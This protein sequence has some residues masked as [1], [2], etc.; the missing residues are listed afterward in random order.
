MAHLVKALVYGVVLIVGC[1][2]ISL[3]ANLIMDLVGFSVYVV[4]A[5]LVVFGIAWFVTKP[6]ED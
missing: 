1:L 3:I 5:L 6:D 4:I 2:V